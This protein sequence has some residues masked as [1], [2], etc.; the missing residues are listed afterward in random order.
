M[1]NP[2]III[3]VLAGGLSFYQHQQNIIAQNKAIETQNINDA[4]RHEQQLIQTAANRFNQDQNFDSVTL[5]NETSEILAKHSVMKDLAGINLN[6]ARIDEEIGRKKRKGKL[7]EWEGKGAIL[8]ATSG[9]GWNIANLLA[10]VDAQWG[11]LDYAEGRNLAFAG[12][13]GQLDNESSMIA[14]AG[15]LAQLNP[16]IKQTFIDPVKPIARPKIKSN[17]GLALLSAGLTGASAGLAFS[18]AVGQAGYEWG[19]WSKG[20][21]KIGEGAKVAAGAG[22]AAASTSGNW[23]SNLRN[24]YSFSTL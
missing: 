10:D 14:Y 15:N 16:Y 13:Q 11:N 8:A 1:C 18:G 19:G 17:T 21:T 23:W 12:Y 9:G 22:G 2:A 6:L 3:G 20:W 24:R 5:S 4:A 7:E